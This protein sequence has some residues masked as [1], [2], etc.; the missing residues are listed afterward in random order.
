MPDAVKQ[1]YLATP[2]TGTVVTKAV[3][4][5]PQRV[6]RTALI[7]RLERAGFTGRM[8][9]AVRHALALRDVTGATLAGLLREGRAMKRDGRLT[10]PQVA[11][12]ASAPMLTRASLVDG[13]LDAGILPTGQVVGRID[14]LPTVAELISQIT[15]EADQTLERLARGG[16]DV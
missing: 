9:S 6:V 10:W 14:A 5:Y 3:D 2:I 12:A 13:R 16:P 15:A 4:G 11:M 1:Q 7:E 8:V